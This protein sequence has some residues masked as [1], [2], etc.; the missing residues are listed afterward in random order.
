MVLGLVTPPTIKKML[1]E[2][3]SE[4]KHPVRLMLLLVCEIEHVAVAKEAEM[5]EGEDIET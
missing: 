4:A 1:S 2:V 5:R 3:S